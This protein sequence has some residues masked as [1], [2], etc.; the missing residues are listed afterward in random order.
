L[1][2][3]EALDA[4]ARDVLEHRQLHAQIEQAWCAVLGGCCVLLSLPLPLHDA[5]KA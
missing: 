2:R 4:H 1:K 5:N 3:D